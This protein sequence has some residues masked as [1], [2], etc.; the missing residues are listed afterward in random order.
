M[1]KR[2]RGEKTGVEKTGMEKT[3][4]KRPEGDGED[5]W[6]K[7]GV[8]VPVTGIVSSNFLLKLRLAKSPF[9]SCFKNSELLRKRYVAAGSRTTFAVR[10]LAHGKI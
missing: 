10:C 6:E 4:E 1:G 3:G 8:K 5:R 7:T 2:P 9:K